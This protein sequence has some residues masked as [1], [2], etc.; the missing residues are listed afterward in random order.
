MA[1]FDQYASRL[2]EA[3]I[4]HLTD[5][6][7]TVHPSEG[8]DV[9]NVPY[10]YDNAFEMFDEQGLSKYVKTLELPVEFV[11]HLEMD[12]RASFTVEGQ[13]WRFGSVVKDDGY[14]VRYEVTT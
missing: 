7:C 10:Q 8:A 6:L 3:A 9:P 13:V 11:G 14:F 2:N 4:L 5:G 1:F 12:L